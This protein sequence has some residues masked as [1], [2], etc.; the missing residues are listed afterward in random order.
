MGMAKAQP[1]I[2]WRSVRSRRVEEEEEAE[3]A[4]G[5]E[6][7]CEPTSTAG[8]TMM[9]DIARAY[10]GG[11]ALVFFIFSVT[12]AAAAAAPRTRRP[13]VVGEAPKHAHRQRRCGGNIM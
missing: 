3:G 2:D 13:A 5:G 1:S 11:R 12:A 10:D 9:R 4:E 7:A 8:E 6:G